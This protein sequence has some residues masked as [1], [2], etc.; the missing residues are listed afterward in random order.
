[1]F[2]LLAAVYPL[3]PAGLVIEIAEAEVVVGPLPNVNVVLGE[4]IV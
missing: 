4:L 2:T 1:M 3:V